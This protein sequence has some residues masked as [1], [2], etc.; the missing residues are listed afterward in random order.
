MLSLSINFANILGVI[1]HVYCLMVYG[2]RVF[3]VVL[4]AYI[5]LQYAQIVLPLPS[6]ILPCFGHFENQKC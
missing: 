4:F 1:V 3:M 2:L 5:S 6:V